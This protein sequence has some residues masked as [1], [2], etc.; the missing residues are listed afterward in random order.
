MVSTIIKHRRHYSLAQVNVYSG[1][2]F[3]WAAIV[4]QLLHQ[5]GKPYILKSAWWQSALFC[6]A[7]AK[8][9]DLPIVV[10]CRGDNAIALFA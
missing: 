5:M 10:G 3:L 9:G 4:C 8:M 7:L 1:F 2:A 6:R